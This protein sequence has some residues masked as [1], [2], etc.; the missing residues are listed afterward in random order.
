MRHAGEEAA[1]CLHLVMANYL[2]EMSHSFGQMLALPELICRRPW[3]C[4]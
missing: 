1:V 4:R 3:G 2:H